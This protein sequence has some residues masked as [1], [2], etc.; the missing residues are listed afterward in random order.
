[1]CPNYFYLIK[2]IIQPVS[3]HEVLNLGALSPEELKKLFKLASSNRVL[4]ILCKNIKQNRY[5][6]I[7]ADCSVLVDKIITAGEEINGQ[8]ARLL[9]KIKN[10]FKENDITFLIVKT[11]RR[12]EYVLSD[13]DILVEAGEFSMAKRLLGEVIFDN[14]IKEKEGRWHYKFNRKVQIDLH[15]TGLDWYSERFININSIWE[16]TQER[17]FLGDVYRFPSEQNEWIFNALNIIYEKFTL[18]YLDFIFLR[19]NRNNPGEIKQIAEN[20]GWATG[21][22]I[23][24]NYLAKIER[25]IIENKQEDSFAL[26]QMFSFLDFLQIFTLRF[27]SP[28][29]NYRSSLYYFCYFIYCK[30]RFIF[31][32][33]CRIPFYGNWF[34]FVNEPDQG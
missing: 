33:R 28:F 15:T 21:L 14:D 10:K 13:I 19:S 17:Q 7:S 30:L 31:S 9:R 32:A 12:N 23:F 26:P 27:F 22:H 2:K 6:G 5:M 8:Y 29:R 1:M 20:Y 25:Q 4:L 11:D 3:N 18:T 24:N 16:N 34:D